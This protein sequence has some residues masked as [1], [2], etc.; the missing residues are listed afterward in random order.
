[1]KI[2]IIG[3]SVVDHINNEIKPGGIYYSAAGLYNFINKDDEISLLTSVSDD[4]FYHFE[5]LY[6][7]INIEHSQKVEKIP[8][9]H[10]KI[11]KT[12]EREECYS[13]IS[14]KLNISSKLKFNNYDGIYIN[15]V[16]GFDIDL[17]DIKF[18]RSNFNG[19]IYF[20]LHTLSRGLDKDNNRNF[21][22]VENANEWVSNIDI[23]QT[24]ENEI[25]TLSNKSDINEI[26]EE[27]MS[28]GLNLLIITKGKS[29][30]SVYYKEKTEI[31]LVHKESIKVDSVHNVGCGDIFGAVYFYSYIMSGNINVALNTANSVA[32]I[33][34]TYKSFEEFKNIKRDAKGFIN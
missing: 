13:N 18:I 2:L 3:H 16:S 28:F 26:I 14:D 33:C 21:R 11:Y 9:V 24:N 4:T 29:G 31:S 5:K 32:G 8:S 7:K 25:F 30:A 22:K 23:L 20:D 12:K 15:M 27:L 34:T 17:S 1:M 6:S 10:L 19:L